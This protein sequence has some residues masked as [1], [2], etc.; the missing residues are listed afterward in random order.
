MALV[1]F[2]SNV[3]KTCYSRIQRGK[4]DMAMVRK[5]KVIVFQTNIPCI[6]ACHQLD[7]KEEKP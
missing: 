3:N 2:L 6:S 7:E 1:K 4:K 5:S